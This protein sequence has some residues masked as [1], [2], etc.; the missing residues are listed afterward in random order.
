M[1]G[2]DISTPIQR[3]RQPAAG[4]TW[5]RSTYDE[6]EYWTVTFINP[7]TLTIHAQDQYDRRDVFQV[8]VFG[9]EGWTYCG[10]RG[11][12]ML[13]ALSADPVFSGCNVCGS[14]PS[15]LPLATACHVGVGQVTVTRDGKQVW[16]GQNERKSV[17]RFELLARETPGDWRISFDSAMSERLYQRHARDSWVLVFRG[18]G[19]A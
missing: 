4:E 15:T 3:T 1:T 6:F 10:H 9:G 19:F 12:G 7:A 17:G 11:P 18:M 13:P 8:G 5:M 16:A 2:P 14:H